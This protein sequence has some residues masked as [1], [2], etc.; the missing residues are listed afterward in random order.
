M[1]ISRDTLG[2]AAE[3]AVASELCRRNIYAQLT[4]GHQKRVD[5]L[6]LSVAGSLTRVEVK[7]KQG[8]EWPNCKGIFGKNAFIVFVDYQAIKSNERPRFFLLSTRDWRR[9]VEARIKEIQTKN[10]SKRVEIDEESVPVFLDEINKH[11][12]PYRGISIRPHDIERYAEAWE[13]IAKAVGV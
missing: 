8:R 2:L 12:K 10:P 11:G 9:V 7:A 1:T 4:L 3:F 13:K 6:V 5:I